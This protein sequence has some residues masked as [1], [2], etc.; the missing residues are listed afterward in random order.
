MLDILARNKSNRN[1][2]VRLYELAKIY[3]KR[4]DGMAD[5]PKV[6]SLGAYGSD[7]DFYTFKG[8]I[9]SVLAGIRAKNVTYEA[10]TTD[11]S[12]HPGRCAVVYSEGKKLGVFGQVHPLVLKNYG[13]DGEVFA[14]ELS[15]PALMDA[16]NDTAT[17]VPLP[18]FPAVTRD[19]AI[20]C[21]TAVTVASIENIMR[22]AGGAILED[23]K[24]FDVYTGA[25]IEEGKRSTAYS[26]TLRSDSGT[27]KDTDAD[28]AVRNILTALETTLGATLR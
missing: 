9:E 11:P 16:S 6:L 5:E 13:M 21:D 25:G 2:S 24:L 3:F 23:V 15:V 22:K 14:A 4:P 8:A 7:M 26:L 27:L 20:V 10:L 28:E 1:D 19:L 12:Y 17:Y 18:R